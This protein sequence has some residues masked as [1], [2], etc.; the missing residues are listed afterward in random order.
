M[1]RLALESSDGIPNNVER[2]IVIHIWN[3]GIKN[4]KKS[5]NIK[6]SSTRVGWG[7]WIYLDSETT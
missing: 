6:K 4:L 3:F 5:I 7:F 2:N 1:A